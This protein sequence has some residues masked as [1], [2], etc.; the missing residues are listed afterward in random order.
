ML[1]GSTVLAMLQTKSER[2]WTP[3]NLNV[4]LP[5]DRATEVGLTLENQG[6]ALAS[7]FRGD[8]N[9][10]KRTYC[11]VANDGRRPI[12][13]GESVDQYALTAVL[14]ATSS[15]LMNVLDG[16][17]CVSFY[18]TLTLSGIC[19]GGDIH[20]AHEVARFG[21]QGLHFKHHS[22]E[23]AAP[24]GYSCAQ[25]WRSVRGLRGIGVFQWGPEGTQ[26]TDIWD[27]APLVWSL[28]GTCRNMRCTNG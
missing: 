1:T 26:Q 6:Y 8:A 5:R 12:I 15:A 3:H 27:R 14:G 9:A 19:R 24:C 4:V 10:I 23:W 7:S 2:E 21:E 11:Y 17:N 25:L 28:G 13:L 22:G 20:H 18:P 16:T